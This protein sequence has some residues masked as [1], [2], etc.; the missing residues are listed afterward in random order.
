MRRQALGPFEFGRLQSVA[1][2]AQRAGIPG[3]IPEILADPRLVALIARRF[4]VPEPAIEAC[5][6]YYRAH[7]DAFRDSDRYAG[8]Q[9]VLRWPEEER[10]RRD[11][12]WARAER[13]IAILH[14]D[15]KMF[16]DLLASYSADENGDRSGRLGPVAAGGLL[17]ALESALFALRPGQIYPTPVATELGL[18]IIMLDRIIPGELPPFSAVQRRIGTIL[19]Q[20][21][22]KAAA[23]RH[24][25]RLAQRYR[26]TLGSDD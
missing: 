8:R 24:L 10:E 26:A 7:E 3:T 14:F 11:E 15:P 17:P 21:A 4:N 9:I 2:E 13:L 22:R 23:A 18:H 1:A 12:I 19:R 20:E 5:E 16:T 25:A 6:R